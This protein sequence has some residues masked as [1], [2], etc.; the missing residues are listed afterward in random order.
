[1]VNNILLHPHD[2][3][4]KSDWQSIFSFL[5]KNIDY[6]RIN[7]FLDLGGGLGDL[8]L[9]I[10][11]KNIKCDAICVDINSEYLEIAKKRSINILLY[12]INNS[13]PFESNSI[14]LVT[15]FGTLHFPYIKDPIKVIEEMVRV[16]KKYIVIDFLY[17]NRPWYFI[18]KTLISNYTHRHY[19]N[20]QI[21]EIFRKNNLNIVSCGSTRNIFGRFF[22]SF[23][24]TTFF[25]L[26]K[27]NA[28]N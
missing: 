9:H 27:N 4:R 20:K 15:C 17:K 21:K 1:M 6:S 11:E 8:T 10:L 24:R 16:S 23:G 25:L 22:F 14:D 13:L 7:S 2:H 26:E 5:D 3:K 19:T 12:D 18:L 28:K